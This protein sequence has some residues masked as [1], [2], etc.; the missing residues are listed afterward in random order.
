MLQRR[1]KLHKTRTRA[2]I[3]PL[4]RTSRNLHLVPA[5][6]FQRPQAA[7]YPRAQPIFS[8]G[9]LSPKTLGPKPTRDQLQWLVQKAINVSKNNVPISVVGNPSEINGINVPVG[10]KPTGALISG[11][12]YLFADNINTVGDG[13]VTVLHELFHLGLQKVIP[14]EDYASL[15]RKFTNNVLVQK[16]VNK[17]H[18]DLTLE[19][20]SKLPE[21]TNAFDDASLGQPGPNQNMTRIVI[22]KS[23]QA[24]GSGYGVVYDFAAGGNKGC[25]KLNF[26]T[27]FRGTE[28]S[29]N[30]C[31]LQAQRGGAG[32]CSGAG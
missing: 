4:S 28:K 29:L 25:K 10:A 30:H 15:L 8:Q 6:M 7:V 2:L 3:P 24:D 12:I 5:T 27:Y 16:Y 18:P 26:V 14:A 21:V 22:C 17:R 11:R 13:Y 9:L 19:D 1:R 31:N 23:T 20:W 32:R